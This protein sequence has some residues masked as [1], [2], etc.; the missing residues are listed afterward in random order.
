MRRR[1]VSNRSRV[2]DRAGVDRIRQ[3]LGIFSVLLYTLGPRRSG[4][5]AAILVSNPSIQP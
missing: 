1:Q 2:A 4:S 3:W 5:P